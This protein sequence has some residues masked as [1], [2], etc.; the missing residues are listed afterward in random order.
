MILKWALLNALSV[1][2]IKLHN[3]LRNLQ[4]EKAFAFEIEIK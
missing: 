1:I 3:N 4:N 2:L